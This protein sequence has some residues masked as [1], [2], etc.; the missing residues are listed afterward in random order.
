M[1]PFLLKS[2]FSLGYSS[3]VATGDPEAKI[4]CFHDSPIRMHFPPRVRQES[5]VCL[6]KLAAGNADISLLTSPAT[7]EEGFARMTVHAATGVFVYC[8]RFWPCSGAARFLY[9]LF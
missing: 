5:V 8:T 9:F 1:P 2:S 4:L 3:L 6:R 7:T